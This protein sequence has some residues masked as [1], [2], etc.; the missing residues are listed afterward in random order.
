MTHRLVGREGDPMEIVALLE[1]ARLVTLTGPGGVGKTT[2][3]RAAAALQSLPFTMV[4]LEAVRDD[5]LVAV[6]IGCLMRTRHRRADDPG[7]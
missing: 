1:D 2:L 3:A 4:E 7:C 6:A 5:D